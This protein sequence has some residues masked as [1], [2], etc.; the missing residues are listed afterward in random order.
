[1]SHLFFCVLI[2]YKTK[3]SY[4][5]HIVKSK[6]VAQSPQSDA[7]SI[8]FP[9]LLTLRT[10]RDLINQQYKAKYLSMKLTF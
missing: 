1:M 7:K 4:Y 3:P 6:K 8:L 9:F 10:L 2:L 5:N